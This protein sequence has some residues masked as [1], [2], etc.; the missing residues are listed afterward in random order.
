MSDLKTG[1]KY[2]RFVWG[3]SLVVVDVVIVLF[4]FG[5]LVFSFFFIL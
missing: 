1:P 3:F 2:G 4:W 5:F